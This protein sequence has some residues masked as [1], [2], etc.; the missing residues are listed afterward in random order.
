MNTIKINEGRFKESCYVKSGKGHPVLLLHG[1]AEDHTIWKYQIASLEKDYTVIAPDVPGSG[2][3]VLHNDEMSLEF[4]ADYV[5]YILDKEGIDQVILLGHSM[6]GYASLAF[7]EMYPDSL[8]ALG[9]I[10]SSAYEDSEEKK[11]T[12]RKSIALIQNGGK[13]A[14]IRAL[15]PNLYSTRS[16]EE[17]KADMQTHL[18]VA[19]SLSS[20]A[21]IAYY[22]AMLK[23]KDRREVLKQISVPVLF[24]I[25]SED[26]AVAPTDSIMQSALP[27]VCVVNQLDEVGHSSMTEKPDELNSMLNSFCKYVL[28]G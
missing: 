27:Q 9:L 13:E 20:E 19:M 22:S 11:E 23:R 14:F 15:I 5:K 12:R 28:K 2:L 4:I 10:Q 16:Q 7:A 8:L 18:A 25:G 1:F 3:S 21:I 24:V 17:K 26:K 6:G